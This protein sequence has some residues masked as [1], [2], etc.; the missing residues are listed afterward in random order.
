MKVERETPMKTALRSFTLVLALAV[1]LVVI[2][3]ARA[4]CGYYPPAQ[5]G[6]ASL[7]PQSWQGSGFGTVSF[8]LASDHDSDEPIVGFWKFVFT[9]QGSEGIPDGT[10][11]D[12][13]Y[14]Q[15]HS[16]HTEITNSSRP[17]ATG[18]FCLGVWKKTGHSKY[19]LNHFTIPWDGNGNQIGPGNLRE[20]VV[21]SHDGSRYEGTFT[22]DQYDQAG[23]L[24]AHIQGQVTGTRIKVGTKVGDIL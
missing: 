2:P 8:L 17:P 11:I 5:K 18:D 12:Q 24:L 20:E 19:K 15:W 3:A 9:S 13:G 22:I 14:T 23:N 10:V 1:G 21:V 4:E 7:L 6:G 16:D